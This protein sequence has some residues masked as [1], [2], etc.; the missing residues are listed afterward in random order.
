MS[1]ESDAGNVIA[2]GDSTPAA[3]RGCGRTRGRL[4]VISGPSGAG[5]SSIMERLLT[6]PELS[7]GPSVTTRPPRSGEVDGRDYFFVSRETFEAMARDSRLLE[8]EE[9]FGHLYGTPRAPVEEALAE[10]GVFVVD[11]DVKGARSIVAV[12]PD[13]ETVFIMPPDEE[14]LKERLAARRTEDTES[15]GRRLERAR[16]EMKE[17]VS[18]RHS[19][20]N[21][22]LGQAVGEVKRIIAEL[23]HNMEREKT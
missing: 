19:V 5:K 22:D 3:S 13:A 1:S 12:Y 23:K 16:Q 7:Y 4:V 11:V 8:Y 21:D 6:D 14:T 17:R 20:C 9:L 10:G 15:V 2:E 18:Y